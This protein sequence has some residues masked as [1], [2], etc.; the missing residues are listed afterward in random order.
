MKHQTYRISETL[1][2]S[3]THCHQSTSLVPAYSDTPQSI[4][5]THL[6]HHQNFF[7]RLRYYPHPPPHFS[8]HHH[9]LSIMLS[10]L[11]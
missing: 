2:C 1:N 3:A 7:L 5:D 4:S 11:Q 8:S 6:P 9:N 10:F